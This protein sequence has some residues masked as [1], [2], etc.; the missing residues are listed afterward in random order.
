MPILKSI[1]VNPTLN[2]ILKQ[3]F[4]AKYTSKMEK[5][6]TKAIDL[7]KQLLQPK[8]A[9][10][11]VE[12]LD[13][14]NDRIVCCSFQSNKQ[15]EFII[16]SVES[17]LSEAKSILI[18]VATIG[19]KLD[20]NILALNQSG[21]NLTAYLLDLIGAIALDQINTAVCSLAE[22]KAQNRSWGVSPFISPGALEGWELK[23]QKKLFGLV[24]ADI[25]GVQL[26]HTGMMNPLKSISGII[27]IG[28]GFTSGKVAPMCSTCNNIS[29]CNRL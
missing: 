7:S 10:Q 22:K 9:Y 29:D 4:P 2:T 20:A 19:P 26:N 28:P 15:Y 1:K 23:G 11:W 25:I 24:D 27:A 17:L 3:G 12:V 14:K 5:E 8:V 18:S 6:V 16:G 21:N 13:I